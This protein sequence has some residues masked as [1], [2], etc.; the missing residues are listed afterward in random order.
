MLPG[1][2]VQLPEGR[3]FNTT[4]PVATV[5]LGWVTVPVMGADGVTGCAVITLPPAAEVQPNEL[6]T[7]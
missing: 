7:V 2:I 4:L 6:V 3:L 1:L 5:Q